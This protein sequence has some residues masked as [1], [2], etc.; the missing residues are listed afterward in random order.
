MEETYN[1]PDKESSFTLI[2]VCRE[3][4]NFMVFV[5]KLELWLP[6]FERLVHFFNIFGVERTNVKLVK[7]IV[8]FR[9]G[10]N[11]VIF[12][13]S[14]DQIDDFSDDLRVKHCQTKNY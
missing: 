2:P 10:E 4:L 8:F 13:L 5:P 7:I 9:K 12:F 1:K 3:N 11:N 6:S 14:I